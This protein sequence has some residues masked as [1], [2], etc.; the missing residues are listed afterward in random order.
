[1]F[2]RAVLQMLPDA[3]DR[4]ASPALRDQLLYSIN[5]LP[6]VDYR[7]S[8]RIEWAWG[9]VER[10]SLEREV[11]FNP[12]VLD[13]SDDPGAAIAASVYSFPAPFLDPADVRQLMAR[14]RRLRPDR[15]LIAL[16]DLPMR[17]AVEAQAQAN[18]WILIE[19]HGR[20]YSP[21]PRDPFSVLRRQ[22]GGVAV[23]ARS[24]PHR[25]R[26]EDNDMGLEL[27]QG[28]P[29]R[30][31]KSWQQPVWM[32]SP[33]PFHNGQILPAREAAWI[34]LHTV[35]RRVLEILGLDAVPVQ[36]LSTPGGWRRYR[37]AALQAAAELRP[38]YGRT[39]SFVH[40]MPE[41]NP[42]QTVTALGGGA[43][44]DLD[45]VLTLLERPGAPLR[46]LVGDVSRGQKLLSEVPEAELA[47]FREGYGLAG[48]PANP[49]RQQLVAAQGSGRARGL[50]RFLDA[51][52]AHFR[53]QGAEVER[54]PLFL[55]PVALLANRDEL[56]HEDFLIS[57]NNVVLESFGDVHR[58]EGFSSLL[59]TGDREAK[60][61]FARLGYE[62][63]FLPP[64]ARSVILN[65]GYRCAS[66]HVR[67]I[68]TRV[69][70]ASGETL[71]RPRSN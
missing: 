26:L 49:L 53:A 23:V 40:P 35:E 54:I 65:G 27:I 70:R 39:V 41:D 57:W 15:T 66:Q 62:M 47:L 14:I 2:R 11:L 71:P 67:R 61:A 45:S 43:G 63:D 1:V 32:R 38:L 55:V 58:A 64:L 31:D 51:I 6:G 20:G 59:Q 18:A 68:G 44:F 42:A 17:K 7:A 69:P 30:L 24:N 10:R 37:Q 25:E 46:A 5:N 50:S 36:S 13:L 29:E 56:E 9:A 16:V 52:A 8:E 3:F 21:W 28:L 22:D 34:S 4:V 33:V 19:T 48:S 12:D 60:K